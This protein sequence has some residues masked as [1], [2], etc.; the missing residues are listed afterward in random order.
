[1]YLRVDREKLVEGRQE[2]WV[3]FQLSPLDQWVLSRKFFVFNMGVGVSDA[4]LRLGTSAD[5]WTSTDF[6]R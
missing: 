6:F 1:M 2:T 4:T 3:D 5:Q